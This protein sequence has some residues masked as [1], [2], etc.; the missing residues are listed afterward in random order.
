MD[1]IMSKLPNQLIMEIIK[2]ADGGLYKHKL[3][4]RTILTHINSLQKYRDANFS[5]KTSIFMAGVPRTEAGLRWLIKIN[6]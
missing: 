5:I 6:K 2:K 4:T 3:T 1:T